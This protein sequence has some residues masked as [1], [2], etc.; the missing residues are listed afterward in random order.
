MPTFCEDYYKRL[1]DACGDV[2]CASFLSA[3][4]DLQASSHS[5]VSDLGQWHSL[6]ADRPESAMLRAAINEYQFS[7]LAAVQGQYRQAFMALRLSFELLL[8]TVHFSANEVQLRLWM[9]GKRDLVWNTIIDAQSGVFSKEFVGAFYAELAQEAMHYRAIAET[10]YRECSEYVH[11]N[12]LTQSTID[13]QVSFQPIV[14]EE[15]HT[16]TKA[17]RLA[18]SFALCA[19]YIRIVGAP[20]RVRLEGVLLDNLG[21]ISVVRQ[22]LGAPVEEQN[23]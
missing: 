22:L 9:K 4:A 16:R 23:V 20:E 6:I 1:H 15:W 18:A 21:H 10:V 13:A 17:M 8:G 14:F 2:L 3:H 11:G 5:F 7:L 12:A 19:R